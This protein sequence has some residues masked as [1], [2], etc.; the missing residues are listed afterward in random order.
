[1]FQSLKGIWVNFDF[2]LDIFTGIPDSFQSLKGIW[3]NF[4]L[5]SILPSILLLGVSI[6][7]RDLGE[8]RHDV[9]APQNFKNDVS[10]PK[11]DLGEF[12]L[13]QVRRHQDAWFDNVSI[14]K[15]DLGEFRQ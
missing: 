13:A 5:I 6:P 2:P 8:F 4:D 15:R 11:R 9:A 7:K 10:I 14:P 1:M 3:V 12:R